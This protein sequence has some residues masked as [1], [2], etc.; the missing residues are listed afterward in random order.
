MLQLSQK[1][2]KI[3]KFIENNIN[4]EKLTKLQD[5]FGFSYKIAY[6]NYMQKKEEDNIFYNDDNDY[7]DDDLCEIDT[8]KK[9]FIKY[10]NIKI[11]DCDN[12][13]IEKI[14]YFIQL[15]TLKSFP[16][17]L[18]IENEYFTVINYI[19]WDPDGNLIFLS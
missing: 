19:C 10:N 8:Y 6:Y 17:I 18:D 11:N 5:I 14:D 1:K 2:E 15:I 16:D 13:N 9:Y 3:K 12:K 7:S 4:I